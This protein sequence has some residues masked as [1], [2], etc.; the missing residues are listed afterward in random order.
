[1]KASCST[2]W[3]GFPLAALGMTILSA[4][5]SAQNRD[6]VI[7]PFEKPKAVNPV[8]APNRAS[9]FVSP[10]NDSTVRWE[11]YATFNPAAVS[12]G[13]C[14]RRRDNRTPHVAPGSRRE[15]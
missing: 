10:M 11:E 12:R 8:I 2:R 6:W 4:S 1:M 3:R 13:G 7:G 5:A 15:R 9:T 14:V